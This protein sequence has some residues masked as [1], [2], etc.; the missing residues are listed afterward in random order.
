MIETRNLT[1][2]TYDKETAHEIIDLIINIYSNEFN[3]FEKNMTKIKD[4]IKD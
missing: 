3:D 1:S 4:E 2:H